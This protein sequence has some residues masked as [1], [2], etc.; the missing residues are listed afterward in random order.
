MAHIGHQLTDDLVE[1]Q[2]EADVRADAIHDVIAASH[3]G[4][5][6]ERCGC[7]S[8]S[9][10]H[11]ARTGINPAVTAGPNHPRDLSRTL[12]VDRNASPRGENT[13]AGSGASAAGHLRSPLHL[14]ASTRKC[15]SS[16]NATRF[17]SRST[18]RHDPAR[19]SGPATVSAWS[20][21]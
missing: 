15:P 20:A 9:F 10:D 16:C 3:R 18:R 5:D 14:L 13:V 4:R 17:P 8:V 7:G 19:I 1:C 21:M 2:A 12:T 11:N 6:D